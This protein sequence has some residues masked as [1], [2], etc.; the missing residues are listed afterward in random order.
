MKKFMAFWSVVRRFRAFLTVGFLTLI[1]VIN[2]LATWSYASKKVDHSWGLNNRMVANIKVGL[3]AFDK[4]TRQIWWNMFAEIVVV[5]VFTL[6]SVKIND[7]VYATW[8]APFDQ[9]WVTRFNLFHWYAI[10]AWGV[11]GFLIATAIVKKLNSIY[12]AHRSYDPE[13][14][15]EPDE[16]YIAK[17]NKAIQER[18]DNEAKR[19]TPE[20]LDPNY[21]NARD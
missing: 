1:P 14:M 8:P 7:Y 6:V 18:L 13:Y 17:R 2:V 21:I 20:E 16:G 12:Q 10:A 19:G 15:D 4:Q 3:P 9:D 5:L 11:S